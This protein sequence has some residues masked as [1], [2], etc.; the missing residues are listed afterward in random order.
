VEEVG[1]KARDRKPSIG[2]FISTVKITIP[3]GVRLSPML[4]PNLLTSYTDILALLFY[5]L[6]TSMKTLKEG[7]YENPFAPAGFSGSH[8]LSSRRVGP[9]DKYIRRLS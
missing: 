4:S 1:G 2:T 9:T 7:R 3:M 6:G 8:A 5:D